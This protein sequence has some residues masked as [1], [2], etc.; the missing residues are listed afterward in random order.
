MPCVISGIFKVQ[1]DSLV[2]NTNK[3]VDYELYSEHT[4]L[5]RST[6]NGRPPY[7]IE[8]EIKLKVEDLNE[9]PVHIIISNRV[10]MEENRAN[11]H[12]VTEFLIDDPDTER[13]MNCSVDRD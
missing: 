2:L 1:N 13:F 8:Q 6:D 3:V 7:S 11:G 10:T 12:V 5:L 4:L 9:A